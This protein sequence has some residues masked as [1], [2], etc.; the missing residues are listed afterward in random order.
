M[1]PVEIEK[2]A[3]AN[4]EM[5]DGLNGAEQLLFQSLRLLYIQYKSQAVTREMARVE[6]IKIYKEYEINSLDLKCWEQA[7]ER[8]RRLSYIVPELKKSGCKLCKRYTNVLFG[9]EID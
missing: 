3:A 9:L 6:K 8:E 2:I 1:L 5:P 4:M 7:R